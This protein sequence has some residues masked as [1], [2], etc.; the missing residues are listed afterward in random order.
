VKA[1][2]N[3]VTA[4]DSVAVKVTDATR[5]R[6]YAQADTYVQ[7]STPSSNFGGEHG[8]LVKPNA[9]ANRVAYLRFDLTPLAGRTVSSA[10]LTTESVIV[11]GN[12]TPS[13][14]RVH[15]HSASGS[16]S[17]N[18]LTYPGRPTLGATLGSFVATRTRATAS[19]SLT[20]PIKTLAAKRTSTLTLGLT[21]DGAGTSARLVNVSTRESP[22]KGAYI[23]V[24]LER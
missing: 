8:M 6:I 10:R 22:S 11:D 17:E 16:W 23:D 5:V 15:A 13:S 19:T 14:V 1:T 21:E 2:A 9:K 18:S 4:T 24:V 7:S 12:T 3:G 20:N